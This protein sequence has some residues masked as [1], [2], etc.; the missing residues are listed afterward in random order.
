M[1]AT[2]IQMPH[3]LGKVNSAVGIKNQ[4]NRDDKLNNY[5]LT[6]NKAVLSYMPVSGV[7]S[8]KKFYDRL[9]GKNNILVATTLR[10]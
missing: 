10:S 5:L 9:H 8:F 3:R 6:G 4:K 2:S 7:R 1:G